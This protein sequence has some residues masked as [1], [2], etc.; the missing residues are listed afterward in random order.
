MQIKD[1]G[2]NAM[3]RSEQDNINAFC[4]DTRAGDIDAGDATSGNVPTTSST[5]VAYDGY[6]T[7]L[8]NTGS[9][10]KDGYTFI[11][12]TDGS[13]TYTP[14]QNMAPKSDIVLS[15]VWKKNPSGGGG[16]TTNN[17]NIM[18]DALEGGVTGNLPASVSVRVIIQLAIL[19]LNQRLTFLMLDMISL[20]GI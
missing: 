16:G 20:V 3:L 17:V 9:L 8:K 18:Y 5:V 4:R 12:W 13:D 2:S 1:T 10:A 15:P 6:Y 11:G 14:G 19:L 7:L